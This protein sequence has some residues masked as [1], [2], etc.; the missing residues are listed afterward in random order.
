MNRVIGIALA[1][2]FSFAST[3]EEPPGI[4]ITFNHVALSVS[5]VERSAAFYRAVFA[6]GDEKAIRGYWTKAM[7]KGRAA[8]P[9]TVSDQ[10]AESGEGGAHHGSQG[11]LVC[12]AGRVDMKP[13][14][15]CA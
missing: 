2:G 8:Q 1:L 11:A 10:A 5:D 3:A 13:F 9:V 4:D 6:L 14:V 7:F 15:Q 12:G